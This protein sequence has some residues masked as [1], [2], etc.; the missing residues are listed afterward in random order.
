[1]WIDFFNQT[2]TFKAAIPRSCG[3][4]PV[5]SGSFV[6][7]DMHV[8]KRYMLLTNTKLRDTHPKCEKKWSK[9]SISRLID[10]AAARVAVLK[11]PVF[12]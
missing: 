9:W 11:R 10:D 8:V 12:R 5:V 2:R 4:K 1:M 3:R 7:N 6:E